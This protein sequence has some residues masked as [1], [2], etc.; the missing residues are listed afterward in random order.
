VWDH[1]EGRLLR[2]DID[3]GYSH[4]ELHVCVED[5]HLFESAQ[6]RQLLAV[7]SQGTSHA[8]HPGDKLRAFLDVWDLG[9][10]PARAQPLRPAH[11]LG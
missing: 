10:A 7:L 3:P 8:R 4:E 9:E 1:E 11:H 2:A 6:G 5:C